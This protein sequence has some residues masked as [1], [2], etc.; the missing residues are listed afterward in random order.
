MARYNTEI[1][2]YVSSNSHF[3]Q[4]GD[5]KSDYEKSIAI[6]KFQPKESK[7]EEERLAKNADSGRTSEN[8]SETILT[9]NTTVTTK[10]V[11]RLTSQRDESK[12]TQN[13]SRRELH[14]TEIRDE[15][16]QERHSRTSAFNSYS[17]DRGVNVSKRE[18]GKG[19]ERFHR[20]YTNSYGDDFRESLWKGGG[21]THEEDSSGSDASIRYDRQ[22]DLTD[23]LARDAR[24][25]DPEKPS[26]TSSRYGNDKHR[27]EISREVSDKKDTE[28]GRGLTS[29]QD[30]RPYTDA[31]VTSFGNNGDAG[32][33]DKI[34]PKEEAKA[35]TTTYSETY[36]YTSS[37][38]ISREPYK[39]ST[40]ES[41]YSRS[42]SEDCGRPRLRNEDRSRS[43]NALDC[44]VTRHDISSLG[45]VVDDLKAQSSSLEQT[46]G[47]LKKKGSKSLEG[48]AGLEKSRKGRKSTSDVVSPYISE[49][50]ALKRESASYGHREDPSEKMYRE[51]PARAEY[52]S[53]TNESLL[54]KFDDDRKERDVPLKDSASS[55]SSSDFPIS[56]IDSQ[57]QRTRD[58]NV[59][60]KKDVHR[61]ESVSATTY[62]YVFSRDGKVL[63]GETKT[64]EGILENGGVL[65]KEAPSKKGSDDFLE[66]K[67]NESLGQKKIHPTTADITEER[68]YRDNKRSER[69]ASVKKHFVDSIRIDTR[70]PRGQMTISLLPSEKTN[71]KKVGKSWRSEKEA[72]MT[73]PA[74]FR[75]GSRNSQSHITTTL[76]SSETSKETYSRDSSRL[77]KEATAKRDST[78]SLAARDTYYLLSHNTFTLPSSEK[79][80]QN[81]VTEN[82]KPNETTARKDTADYLSG[83]DAHNHN[84][85]SQ[86]SREHKE[87]T[88]VMEEVKEVKPSRMSALRQK[89]EELKIT[90]DSLNGLRSKKELEEYV[91]Q[92]PAKKV[93]IEQEERER[94]QKYVR[95][96]TRVEVKVS[97]KK[98]ESSERLLNTAQHSTAQQKTAWISVGHGRAQHNIKTEQSATKHN[99]T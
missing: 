35:A 91:K 97:Y 17:H 86:A 9:R 92:H 52:I 46:I 85:I 79:T 83:R 51:I 82:W 27:G 55:F 19:D 74:A 61:S 18:E 28:Y 38:G 89:I 67:A 36:S 93:D 64:E 29:S 80:E 11:T 15:G 70:D 41:R 34:S 87:S 72:V 77:E 63:R 90:V 31:N 58:T 65:E 43:M 25:S 13:R 81:V 56:G 2:G 33:L 76:L 42:R 50:T 59:E 26:S 47:D 3:Q 14:R 99:F 6:F 60:E 66:S 95:S 54:K 68:I 84:A 94:I 69:E 78:D 39:T 62:K 10:N 22:F 57:V 23:S 45:K 4:Y 32:S 48:I 5:G 71:G 96:E 24:S 40:T 20:S 16:I 8:I 75:V 49:M 98:G 7:V 73:D 53:I 30:R 12:V 44:E 37:T 1:G 21:Q 88:T